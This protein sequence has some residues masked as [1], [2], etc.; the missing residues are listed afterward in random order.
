MLGKL[1]LQLLGAHPPHIIFI[2]LLLVVLIAMNRQEVIRP[3]RACGERGMAVGPAATEARGHGNTID[4]FEVGVVVTLDVDFD[5]GHLDLLEAAVELADESVGVASFAWEVGNDLPAGT[6][7]GTAGD[8]AEGWC[9]QAG[10]QLSEV[11]E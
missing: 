1:D 7:R 5:R 9:Q 6:G 2:E 10:V 4:G 3:L 8:F 11:R